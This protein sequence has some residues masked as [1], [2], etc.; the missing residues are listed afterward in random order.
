MKK[1]FG[2]SVLS[3]SLVLSATPISYAN[4]RGDHSKE[5]LFRR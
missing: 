1:L 3:A 5:G 2:V 4:K